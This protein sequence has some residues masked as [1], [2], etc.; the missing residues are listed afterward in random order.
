M[1]GSGSGTA[2]LTCSKKSLSTVGV[3]LCP[4]GRNEDTKAWN[5]GPKAQ[6]MLECLAGPARVTVPRSGS[7]G[8]GSRSPKQEAWVGAGRLV[9][10]NGERRNIILV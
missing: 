2:G 5:L 8:D 9:G 3:G 7:R 1:P 10:L 4:L 6:G